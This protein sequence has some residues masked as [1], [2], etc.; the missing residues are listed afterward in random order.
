MGTG[1]GFTSPRTVEEAA[2]IGLQLARQGD[3]AGYYQTL[4][5]MTGSGLAGQIPTPGISA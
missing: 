2:A 1:E 3:Y 5:D 4:M